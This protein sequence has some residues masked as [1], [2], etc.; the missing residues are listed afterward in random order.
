M[1]GFC[2]N[3]I[4]DMETPAPATLPMDSTNGPDD[5]KRFAPARYP[6]ELGERL[7]EDTSGKDV[8][9]IASDG[10]EH[11]HSIVLAVASNVFK[12]MFASDFIEGRSK[13]VEILDKTRLQLRFWL[14]L[15]YTGQVEE[16]DWIADD[17]VMRSAYEVLQ[18]TNSHDSPLHRPGYLNCPGVYRRAGTYRGRPK[19]KNVEWPSSLR[20]YVPREDL[21]TPN[22]CY[23]YFDDSSDPGSPHWRIT[24]DDLEQEPRAQDINWVYSQPGQDGCPPLGSWTRP[25]GD[26][27]WG[28]PDLE[29]E[30]RALLEVWVNPEPEDPP[31]ALLLTALELARKYGVDYMSKGL[32]NL[33]TARLTTETFEE[34]F[35]AAIKID[36]G[37][38]RSVCLNFARSHWA[39]H[40]RLE[41]GDFNESAVSFELRQL[42]P[43]KENKRR[44]FL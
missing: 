24:A 34:I 5:L 14:R 37:P 12:A 19:F 9:L 39:I 8:Q 27:R 28:S 35:A 18:I 38:L 40:S 29:E 43:K 4:I 16:N 25:P 1:F 44:R 31:G 7:F 22:P 15:L 23:L 2:S 21:G 33:I 11:A 3:H 26:T 41:M 6:L 36:H 20:N 30:Q 17:N 32:T 13:K 42:W 10:E